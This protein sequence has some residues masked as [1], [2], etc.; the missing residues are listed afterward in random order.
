MA[1]DGRSFFDTACEVVSITP[2]AVKLTT[3]RPRR[4]SREASLAGA[5]ANLALAA[6]HVTRHTE[7]Y[8]H[9]GA[10]TDRLMAINAADEARAALAEIEL[11]L[12]PQAPGP[13][14]A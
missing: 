2:P 11:L 9:T 1:D 14:A 7:A 8:R 12:T 4:P 3:L 5:Q 13:E 10:E 6:M